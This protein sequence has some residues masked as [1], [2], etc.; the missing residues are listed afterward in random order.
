MLV[1]C[2]LA[3]LPLAAAD[4]AAM[5]AK[6]ETKINQLDAPLYNPFIE[7]Y[8]LD[9]V[10]QLRADMAALK[11]E[12][13]RDVVDRELKV[14]AQAVTYATDTVTYFF[15][16]IAAVSSVLVIVGWSSIRDIKDKVHSVAD[17]EMAKL[18]D[19]Y[20]SRLEL[21]EKQLKQKAR[22]IE[23]NREEIELTQEVQSLWLRAA[24]EA[25]PY[26]KI[27]IYDQVLKLRPQD[28]EALTYKA[29]A[30]LELGEPLWALNLCNQALQID[31]ENSHAFFQL[32]C[33]YTALEQFDEALKNLHKALEFSTDS[34]PE[35]LL[36]DEALKPLAGLEAFQAIR[37]Q[38]SQADH[39]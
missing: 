33:A 26:N 16:L 30:A 8:M 37:N 14:S 7:R 22:H 21:I 1:F 36:A 27:A 11:V 17:A 19:Q 4:K 38:K 15:Y 20:E 29:D 32:A 31:A 23:E 39:A 24:Q 5:D 10:K 34:Y 6:A 28:F 18:V 12:L 2:L 35:A 25:N 9:E 13:T 3:S